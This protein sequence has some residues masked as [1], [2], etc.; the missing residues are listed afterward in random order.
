LR[1][2]FLSTDCPSTSS[3]ITVPNPEKAAA[4]IFSVKDTPMPLSLDSATASDG[5]VHFTTKKQLMVLHIVLLEYLFLG[6]ASKE[7]GY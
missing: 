6:G 3:P 4:N 5:V 1:L 2:L 7:T